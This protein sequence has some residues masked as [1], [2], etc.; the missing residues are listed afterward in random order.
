[1][2]TAA[3]ATAIDDR[4]VQRVCAEFLEMPGLQL[5]FEQARRLWG[6]DET[7]CRAVLDFLVQSRFL[8]GTRHGTYSRTTDGF[9]ERPHL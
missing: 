2:T 6:L 8:C 9:A 1:M 3:A 5:T 7:T 4:I